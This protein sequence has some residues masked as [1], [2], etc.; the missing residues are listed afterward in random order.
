MFGASGALL[1]LNYWLVVARPRR[2]ALGELCHVDSPLMRWNRRLWCAS[3][4]LYTNLIH[5]AG[6][7]GDSGGQ[8]DRRRGRPGT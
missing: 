4:A 7:N 8:A 2:C 5:G 6:G 1:A 3:V